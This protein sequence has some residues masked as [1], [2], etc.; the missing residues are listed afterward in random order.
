[1]YIIIK[2]G[3]YVQGVWV[4]DSLEKA[5][6]LRE[7]LVNL[8]KDDYHNYIIFNQKL[9]EDVLDGSELSSISKTICGYFTINIGSLTFYA[10]TKDPDIANISLDENMKFVHQLSGN[11]KYKTKS[12]VGSFYLNRIK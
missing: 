11:S 6:T 1:M 4:E 9:G 8:D 2:Q 7:S 10:T 5:E 3:V 12:K